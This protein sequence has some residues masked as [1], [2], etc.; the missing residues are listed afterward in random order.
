MRAASA[1]SG[2][3]AAPDAPSGV[4]RWLRPVASAALALAL[5]GGGYVLLAQVAGERGIAPTAATSD[6]EVKGISVDVTAGSAEEAR[7][8]GWREAQKLAWAKVGGPQLSEGQLDALV[9]AIVIERERLGPRRYIATLGVVFDRQRAGSYLGGGPQASRSAPMLL[10]PV[11]VSGGAYTTYEQRNAWQRAWAEFNPGASRINYVRPSGAGGDSL[12]INF[13]QT[14]RHSRA[15]WRTTLDQYGASDALMAFARLDHQFP[16]GPI[17][18]TFTVRYG[19]DSRPLESFTLKADNPD[20]LPAMLAQAVE[21][22]D[23]IFTAALASG[24]LR[25]DPSLRMGGEGVIDPAIAR[26][27]EIG[28]AARERSA[29]AAAAAAAGVPRIEALPVTG[30]EPGEAVVRSIVVQFATPDAGAF[31]NAIGAVRSTG[32]VR[33]VGVTSTAIGGTSVMSVSFAGSLDELAA[34]LEA[35]GFS[36][37]RGANALAISR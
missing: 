22:M 18:G 21:R 32:G 9:S 37:R 1:L 2:P 11:E 33:S 17:S 3:D 14:G 23:A 28:R 12:L 15:W 34:A 36:V 35:R 25:P 7:A 20:A 26:L 19:P 24:K 13:G 29:A 27:I 5:L 6:I 16:G 4:H 31:D 8:K 30:V 10:I